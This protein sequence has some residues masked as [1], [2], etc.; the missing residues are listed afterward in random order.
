MNKILFYFSLSACMAISAICFSKNESVKE[1]KSEANTYSGSSLIGTWVIS[2]IDSK[3]S[4]TVYKSNERLVSTEDAKKK[5]AEVVLKISMK[6]VLEKDLKIGVTRF[7]FG[8]NTYEFYKDSKLTFSG[9][10]SLN[11]Q[12]NQLLLDFGTGEDLHTKENKIIKLTDKLLIMESESHNKKV[13]L[14]F[15]KK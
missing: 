6:K 3:D 9:H 14:T 12:T 1:Y 10:W 2:G 8:D 11:D 13:I 4:L 7:I 5:S 15:N